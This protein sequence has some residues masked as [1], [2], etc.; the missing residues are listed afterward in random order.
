MVSIELSG[1]VTD[2]EKGFVETWENVSPGVNYII[3]ENRRGDEE[4]LAV[5]GARPFKLTT[6]DRML[7]EDKIRDDRHNPFKNGAFRPVIVP[8]DVTIE[9]NPNAMSADDIRRLFGASDVAWDE[10][11]NV[12][13]SPSTFKRMIDM[14][15][16][17]EADLSHRRYQQLVSQYDE[18]SQVGKRAI[19]MKSEDEI[20]KIPGSDSAPVATTR[21]TGARKPG[22]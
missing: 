1:S 19:V 17:G 16:G 2:K 15:D 10:Y 4:Y 22:A 14:A 20:A 6:Y 18:F 3:R 13:D 21:R 12:I 9:S 11:M 7:T 8:E 5:E